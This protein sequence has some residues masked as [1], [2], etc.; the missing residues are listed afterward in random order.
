MEPRVAR[1]SLG[2]FLQLYFP[3]IAHEAHK[4]R[5]KA[6]RLAVKATLILSALTLSVGMLMWQLAPWVVPL[7]LGKGYQQTIPVIR[8]LSPIPFLIT[9]SQMVGNN[10]AHPLG[11]DREMSR[12]VVISAVA[13]AGFC[14]FGAWAKG[15]E[16]IAWAVVSAHLLTAI[17]YVH[18]L[19]KNHLLPTT[20]ARKAAV[21]SPA[22]MDVL[23]NSTLPGALIGT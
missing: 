14:L 12:A 16:G 10:W 15:V 21:R 20:L 5:Q 13:F 2:P 23:G 11:L 6:A 9:F 18:L 3:H 7:L 22:P 4:D 1:L 17:L 19:W 8:I